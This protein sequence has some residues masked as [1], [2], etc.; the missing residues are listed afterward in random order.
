[1][2]PTPRI[3]IIYV[4]GP[5]RGKNPLAVKRNIRDAQEVGVSVMQVGGFPLVP[6]ANTEYMDGAFPDDFFLDGDLAMLAKCDAIVMTP[7]FYE[8]VGAMNE[9][10]FAKDRGIPCFEWPVDAITLHSWVVNFKNATPS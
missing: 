8:S 2:T 6:H 10:E 9:R 5:Y 3:P 4:A 1:M 7:R